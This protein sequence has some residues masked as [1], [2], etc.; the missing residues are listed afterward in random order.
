MRIAKKRYWQQ[1]GSAHIRGLVFSLS[2]EEWWD[3]WQQSGP[4]EERGR[5]T[6]QYCMSRRGDRGGYTAENVFIQLHSD[7]SIQAN[8]GVPHSLEQNKKQSIRLI[9]N[10]F[11]RYLKGTRR[12]NTKSSLALNSLTT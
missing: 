3:I 9:G 11:G 1:K 5:G 7:N 10:T 6:G 12:L 8:R 2:F 4:W